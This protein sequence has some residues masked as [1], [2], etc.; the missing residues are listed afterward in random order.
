MLDLLGMW[1]SSYRSF[2]FSIIFLDFSM[3]NKKLVGRI[4]P[5]PTRITQH[6]LFSQLNFSPI[7]LTRKRSGDLIYQIL[8]HKKLLY[9]FLLY[10]RVP[11]AFVQLRGEVVRFAFYFLIISLLTLLADPWFTLV[12]FQTWWLLFSLKECFLL[13]LTLHKSS[14]F[15]LSTLLHIL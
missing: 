14:V 1:T 11:L 3:E 4:W 2:N 8:L 12:Y 10:L 6:D 5:I 9:P 7:Q 13:C 15:H